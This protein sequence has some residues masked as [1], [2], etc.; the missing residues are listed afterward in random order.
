MFVSPILPGLFGHS[1]PG[2][3]NCNSFIWPSINLKLG[4]SIS[5]GKNYL[6]TKIG[7][8]FLEMT[9]QWRH[10]SFFQLLCFFS[11]FAQIWYRDASWYN[12]QKYKILLR[13]IEKWRHGDLTLILRT[14]FGE[15]ILQRMCCH[16]NIKHC[17]LLKFCTEVLMI[18]SK[19]SSKFCEDWLRNN[20][21]VTSLLSWMAWF[22]KR[23]DSRICYHGN[24][25]N[26]ILLK[27]GTKMQVSISN[28]IQ[29]FLEI[30][31]EM[32]SQWRHYYFGG[33]DLS[34]ALFQESVAMAT[35]RDP[36]SN[37]YLLTNSYIFSGKVTKFGWIIF[38]P[39]WVMGKKPQGWCRTP[40]GQDRVKKVEIYD[41]Y[42][43]TLMQN[44]ADFL[45]WNKFLF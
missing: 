25:N 21:T 11:Y 3:V 9:S 13:L 35:A 27:F 45:T 7:E 16:G 30:D 22:R 4:T 17:I 18:I 41:F 2:G 31:W 19:N 15:S 23:A 40:S 42:R 28:K 20:V 44:A 32:T 1:Q 10:F 43:Q 37:F 34:E 12:K 5:M 24:I 14:R 8:L 39:L 6:H 36:Y 33:L 38:L 26:P 29:N